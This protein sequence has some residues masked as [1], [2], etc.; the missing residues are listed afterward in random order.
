MNYRAWQLKNADTAGE[1]AL[2]AAGYG[3]LLARVL[4][5]R[6]IAQPQAAAALLEE[7]PPLSDPFLLKDMDKAVARIQQAIENGETIVIFGD[8]DVDGVSATAIL[9]ECL[10]NLGAQVRCKLPT[11]EGGG[12]G[13]VHKDQIDWYE[14]TSNALKAENGG[15]PVPSLLFQH[16]VVPEVYNMF[17]EVSKGTKGA[18]RGNANHTSQYYVTNPDYIDAGHL[19]EGPCPANTANDGQ[20]DSWVKQG[21]ILG[22]IFGHDHVNDYA[23]T[24][25]GIRLLAAP[26]VTFYSYGNY[27]GVRTI[28]LD[29]SNL[30]T[31]QTQVIP[32]DKLMDYTVKN[33]YIREHGY[34]EYK[35][36][37]IPA[38]CGGIAGLAALTAV[39]IVLVK[40]IKKHKA[41]K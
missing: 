4:A 32:A 41:K 37:F 11:R 7:E 19:N 1:S 3:P 5:C 18:V 38:L 13:Y 26:A 6:G 22:A 9:Y 28:D 35:S 12:Y 23:G 25:K 31:F 29:E 34:Y 14:R 8:Y 40:V 24:Y 33:P 16:I 17:T 21:D 30:S 27:R 2:L 10:T 36:V 20:L 15:K 39:I